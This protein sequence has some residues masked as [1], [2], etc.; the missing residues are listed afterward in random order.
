MRTSLLRFLGMAILVISFTGYQSAIAQISGAIS[1][2]TI[3]T[4]GTVIAD[5][6]YVPAGKTLTIQ[7][8]TSVKF[9]KALV[10]WN[11]E[12][13]RHLGEPDHVHTEL[14]FS[15]SRRMVRHRI[16]KYRQRRFCLQLLHRELWRRW[17]ECGRD[18]LQD[19]RI[20][21][22]HFQLPCQF[23]FHEWNQR[24]RILPPYLEINL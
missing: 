5:S 22:Q 6:V 16:S 7:P 19:R 14:R 13:K 24:S 4:A 12:R 3:W 23:Q 10:V 18:L 15:V 1:N 11:P 9:N 8:G 21:H 17:T 2:D 20:R